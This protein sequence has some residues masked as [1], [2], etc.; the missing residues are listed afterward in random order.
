MIDSSLSDVNAA[1]ARRGGMVMRREGGRAKGRARLGKQA[2]DDEES[3]LVGPKLLRV[4]HGCVGVAPPYGRREG[5]RE[6]R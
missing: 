3:V 1:R 5:E 4:A 6:V 2:D